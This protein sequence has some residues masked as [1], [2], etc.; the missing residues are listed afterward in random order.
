MP[1]AGLGCNI[2]GRL[3]TIWVVSYMRVLRDCRRGEESGERHQT[4]LET[5][6]YK[7]KKLYYCNLAVKT[8]MYHHHH[9]ILKA[10]P[11]R[12]NH[13]AL[14][15]TTLFILTY[16]LSPI[17]LIKPFKFPFRCLPRNHLPNTFPSKMLTMNSLCR[18]TWP[19]CRIM[20]HHILF[21]CTPVIF[22]YQ[23]S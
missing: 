13:A 15:S 11:C 16:P 17:A 22:S 18:I 10:L 5:D 3:L 4:S 23:T 7:K 21:V 12:C 19:S 14:W 20:P 8:F 2:W 6:D 9:R 1:G